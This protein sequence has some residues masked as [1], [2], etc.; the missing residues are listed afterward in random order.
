MKQM[1]S[2]IWI[3]DI[4]IVPSINSR[5]NLFKRMRKGTAKVF[6]AKQFSNPGLGLGR[7]RSSQPLLPTLLF[8]HFPLLVLLL[9]LGW[10][11][12]IPIEALTRDP[13]AI[14]DKPFYLG[15]LSSIGILFWCASAAF[16]LFSFLVLKQRRQGRDFANFFLASSGITLFLL[17]DDLFLIHEQIFPIYLNLSENLVLGGHVVILLSY[18][19]C[20]RKIILR[21]EFL[22]LLA[23]LGFFALSIL[24]DLDMIA[25]PPTSVREGIEALL[26][27]GLKLLGIAT[28]CT[29]FARAG[30]EQINS[31]IA[32]F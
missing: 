5:R 7:D 13:L 29:Y 6:R 15:A 25:L 4:G 18:L 10:Q 11:T 14:L 19:I 31:A 32:R 27:D 20:F 8:I 1:V 30:L 26:E 21:T 28:W 23:A 2:D 22:I 3:S 24:A 16:C 9:L 17:L 12:W